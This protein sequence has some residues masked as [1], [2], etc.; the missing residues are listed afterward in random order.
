MRVKYS[1]GL[2]NSS[3]SS[4]RYHRY[5]LGRCCQRKLISCPSWLGWYLDEKRKLTLGESAGIAA[6]ASGHSRVSSKFTCWT[7]SVLQVLLVLSHSSILTSSH[8]LL[9]ACLRAFLRSTCHSPSSQQPRPFFSEQ[10][11]LVY[12]TQRLLLRPNCPAK[13]RIVAQ[14]HCCAVVCNRSCARGIIRHDVVCP[15]CSSSQRSLSSLSVRT[16][17]EK[18]NEALADCSTLSFCISHS[19]LRSGTC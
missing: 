11:C 7:W 4:S 18:S 10:Q 12:C 6:P 19:K 3:I 17:F 8:K 5:H 1:S 15:T 14:V 9:I 13:L 2:L 16:C